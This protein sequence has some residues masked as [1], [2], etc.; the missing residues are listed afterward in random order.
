[1]ANKHRLGPRAGLL[2]CVAV[3]ALAGCAAIPLP[4]TPRQEAPLNTDLTWEQAKA[5]AQKKELEIAD[6]VPAD[7]VVKIDQ[8]EKG[9]LLSCKGGQDNWNGATTVTV[10]SGTDVDA[11]VKSIEAHYRAQGTEVFVDTDVDGSYMIQLRLPEP[12][13][14]Y[15]IGKDIEDNQLRIDSGSA[16]FTLPEDIYRGGAF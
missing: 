3:V 1:M 10:A 8:K 14:N 12:G 9:T 5:D 4:G 2:S 16:C 15:V 7:L 13:E 11:I 6:L